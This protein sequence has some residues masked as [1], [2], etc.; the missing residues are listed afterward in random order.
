MSTITLKADDSFIARLSHLSE[1]LHLTKSEVIRR[2]V[3]EYEQL[4]YRKNLQEQMKRASF[5][6][7]EIDEN[8]DDWLNDGLN[9]D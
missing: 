4:V 9:N 7:R 5:R 8:I 1:S 3:V 6:T 2:S